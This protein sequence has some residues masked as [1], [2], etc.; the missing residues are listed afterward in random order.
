MSLSN[1]SLEP[2]LGMMSNMCTEFHLHACYTEQV[3]GVKI[4]E[5][6]KAICFCLQTCNLIRCHGGGGLCDKHVCFI[7]I[8]AILR[9]VLEGRGNFKEKCLRLFIVVYKHLVVME[10]MWCSVVF[11]MHAILSMFLE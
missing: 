4:N 7:L 1:K 11:S 9:K 2:A 8:H 3:L 6:A 5:S 10:K